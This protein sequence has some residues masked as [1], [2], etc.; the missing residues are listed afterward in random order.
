M[1][2]S[3]QRVIFAVFFAGFAVAAPATVLWTAGYRYN[4]VT[5]RLEKTGVLQVATVPKRATIQLN[6][7]TLENVA[8]P[9]TITALLPE[10][11]RVTVQ[12]AGYLPWTKRLPVASGKST[13]AEHMVLFRDAAPTLAAEGVFAAAA[14]DQKAARVA[15][16]ADVGEWWELVVFN[17]ERERQLAGRLGKDAFRPLDEGAALISP[18]G[19]AAAFLGID[20]FGKQ[21]AFVGSTTP[22]NGHL[23]P[24]RQLAGI[25]AVRWLPD[26]T[27]MVIAENGALTVLDPDAQFTAAAT[28]EGRVDDARWDGAGVVAVLREDGRRVL[29][30]SRG[31]TLA[32]EPVLTLADSTPLTLVAAQHP[33]AL[34]RA[35][36][37][38]E[39]TLVRVDTA[40]RSRV[41]AV[42]ADWG[43]GAAA[44]TLLV[45]T[46]VEVATVNLGTGVRSTVTR[47]AGPIRDCRWHPSGSHIAYRAGGGAYVIETDTRDVPVRHALFVGTNLSAFALD[48]KA[49]TAG[50][51][52]TMGGT[53][54][55]WTRALE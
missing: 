36:A 53:S 51:A 37:T 23:Q 16:I 45:C 9:A 26:G 52:G 35:T 3:L 49:R 28:I 24:L 38:G 15:A 14:F 33:W 50:F 29:A 6:G 4:L 34:V 8:T 54:G 47:H 27:P 11:Y 46:E 25:N 12:K 39:G 5:N 31:T 13:F 41:D 44:N 40:D 7:T 32:F 48:A 21:T 43:V 17:E 10:T 19:L 18:D 55:L 20:R 1:T 2:R 22:D 42:S 30:R